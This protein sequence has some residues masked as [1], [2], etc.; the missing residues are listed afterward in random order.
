MPIVVVF[1]FQFNILKGHKSLANV[2]QIVKVPET[3]WYWASFCL[4]WKKKN[5]ANTTMPYS[6][7]KHQPDNLDL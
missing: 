7:T 1:L 3:G 2:A 5:G 6:G 4:F